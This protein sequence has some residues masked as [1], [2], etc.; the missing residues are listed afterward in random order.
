MTRHAGCLL[1]IVGF[2]GII[3]GAGR[4]AETGTL[5]AI[6][7]TT[8]AAI[9]AIAATLSLTR[10]TPRHHRH[11]HSPP[12]YITARARVANTMPQNAAEN[13][14]NVSRTRQQQFP[15]HATEWLGLTFCGKL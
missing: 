3:A 4:L 1:R 5:T 12:P 6:T 14:P 9:A 2:T 7:T 8:D 13:S 15:C 11:T 10:H